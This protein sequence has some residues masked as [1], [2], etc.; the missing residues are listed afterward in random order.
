MN[1]FLT[2]WKIKTISDL[3]K[4]LETGLV[5]GY[6]VELPEVVVEETKLYVNN[7]SDQQIK[8]YKA[9]TSDDIIT[10]TLFKSS[11][12]T[13]WT[14]KLEIARKF[15]S[16][17]PIIEI[18][19]ANSNMLIDT[20]QLDWNYIKKTLGGFPEEAEVILLPGNYRYEIS[21]E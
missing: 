21:E 5:D 12:P 13:S 4:K 15:K 8:L 20:T 1:K 14:Y 11:K 9:M 10:N 16:D 2:K 17:L 19:V 6:R 7:D 18:F 3:A